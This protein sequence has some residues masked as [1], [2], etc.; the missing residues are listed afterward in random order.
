MTGQQKVALA[1]LVLIA[2]VMASGHFVGLGA[3]GGGDPTG[4]YV[5]ELLAAVFPGI[6]SVRSSEVRASDCF[7]GSSF[8]IGLGQTCVAV[9]SASAERVRSMRLV[10]RD[11][12]RVGI[13]FRSK[14]E[15][16]TAMEMTLRPEVAKTPTLSIFEQGA[17]LSLKCA[18]TLDP[19]RP[20]RVDLASGR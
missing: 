8:Q 14:G 20:C 12:V 7:S 19:D 1:V 3:E 4:G 15:H 9:I 5:A 16:G 2:V 17:D 11:G 6:E 10:L 18:M 13:A